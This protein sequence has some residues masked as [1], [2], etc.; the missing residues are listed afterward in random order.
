[1]I[2]HNFLLENPILIKL[3]GLGIGLI[4]LS[5]DEV[6]DLGGLKL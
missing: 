4:G 3:V 5:K 6:S 1:M 2:W